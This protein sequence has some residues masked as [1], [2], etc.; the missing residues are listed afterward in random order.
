MSTNH[1]H[2]HDDHAAI[3]HDELPGYYEILE[4]SLREL[5]IEK[6]V[7]T[8]DELRRQI[9]AMDTRTPAVGA[10]LVVRAW[11]DPEFKKRLLADGV[12]ASAEMG[13]ISW[14]DTAFTVLE[15]TED[16]HHLIVCTLCSCYPRSIIGLP[17]DWYK[18]K[19]YRSRAVREPRA[20]IAE[21]GTIIPENIQIIINDS[22]ANQRY[23]VLPMRPAGTEHFNE[24]QLEA[25]VTR[26]TLIGVTLPRI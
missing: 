10:K 16:T 9:E 1:N 12:A 8:A 17:P 22:T 19:E 20:V 13:V 6:G 14:D 18:S 7:I 26:D 2:D 5:L 23:M 24:E 11:L 21:F 3:T 4:I 25:I 15:D